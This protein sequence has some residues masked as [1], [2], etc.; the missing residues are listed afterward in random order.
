LVVLAVPAILHDL[1][2]PVT[3]YCGVKNVIYH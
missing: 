2:K 3:G 1:Y